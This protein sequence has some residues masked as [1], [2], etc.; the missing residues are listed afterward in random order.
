MG[1]LVVI[2]VA[3]VV[4]SNQLWEFYEMKWKLFHARTSPWEFLLFATPALFLYVYSSWEIQTHCW[5]YAVWCDVKMMMDKKNKVNNER[6]WI[7]IKANRAGKLTFRRILIISSCGI[8]PLTRFTW[9]IHLSHLTWYTVG[10]YS[11]PSDFK[12]HCRR[13][14]ACIR[15]VHCCAI[16]QNATNIIIIWTRIIFSFLLSFNVAFLHE[17]TAYSQSHRR[18]LMGTSPYSHI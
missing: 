14:L 3:L 9:G 17:I 1:I 8:S 5:R 13:P 6:N 7:R 12:K 11:T 10:Q 4:W 16:R 2:D 18:Y 15:A